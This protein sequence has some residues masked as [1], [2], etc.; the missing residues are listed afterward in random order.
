MRSLYLLSV[1]LHL[2]SAVFWIGGMFFL[3][4]VGAPLLR[5][6]DPETRRRLFEALGRRFRRFSWW[7]I[8]LM[9]ATGVV[10]LWVPG[11]LALLTDPLFWGSDFGQ[12]LALKLGLVSVMLVLAAMHDFWLGPRTGELDPESAEAARLRRWSAWG[13]RINAILA[14]AVLYLAARLARGG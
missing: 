2:T 14:V 13:G 12:V 5:R 9:V 4:V 1:T 3:G 11:R 10:N 8:A 6:E 7:V